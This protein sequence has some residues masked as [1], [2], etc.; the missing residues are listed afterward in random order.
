M[1]FATRLVV[2]AGTAVLSLAAGAPS[3]LTSPSAAARPAA[4]VSPD[5][6]TPTNC[7]FTT[8]RP[9]IR[10]GS[11]GA[12]VRQAQCYLNDSLSPANH[13]PLSVDGDFGSRTE[14]AVRTFQSCV[15]IT[16]DGVVGHNTWAQLVRWANASTFAC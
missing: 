8:R 2:A 14:A 12:A 11:V 1:R 7:T 15:H 5:D 10:R 6:G 16:V 3:V 13:T 9:T 4:T